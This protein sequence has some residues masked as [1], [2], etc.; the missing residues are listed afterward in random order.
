MRIETNA[1]V[2]LTVAI[3]LIGPARVASADDGVST[4]P[5]PATLPDD[6]CGMSQGDKDFEYCTAASDRSPSPANFENGDAEVQPHEQ[7]SATSAA[8][9]AAARGAAMGALSV[10]AVILRLGPVGVILCGMGGPLC[11]AVVLAGAF[12]GAANARP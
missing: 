5:A 11:V 3:L 6:P 8:H 1:V 2:A 9:G 10:V 4:L 7:P 12:V